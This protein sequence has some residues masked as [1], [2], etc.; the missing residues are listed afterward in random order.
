MEK[1]HYLN[2]PLTAYLDLKC[3]ETNSPWT[4]SHFQPLTELPDEKCKRCGL[5]EMD[6]F[7]SDDVFDEWELCSGDFDHGIY[8]HYKEKEF[9]ATFTIPEYGAA[10]IS[11]Y[12][13]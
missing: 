4:F 10:V 5:Y 13:L 7:K 12:C 8:V 6:T 9:N 11:E 2:K 3:W 1:L